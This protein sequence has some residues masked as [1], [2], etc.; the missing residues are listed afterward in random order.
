MIGLLKNEKKRTSIAE[1]KRAKEKMKKRG[2][3]KKRTR[4]DTVNIEILVCRIAKLNVSPI[5]YFCV[6]GSEITTS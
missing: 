2:S 5:L 6:Y 1:E 3:S 4:R